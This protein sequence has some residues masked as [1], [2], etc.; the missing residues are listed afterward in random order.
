M[1]ICDWKGF[2][3]HLYSFAIAFLVMGRSASAAVPYLCFGAQFPGRSA[4]SLLWDA[5]PRPQSLLCV[6]QVCLFISC[7]GPVCPGP[8][9]P[10]PICSFLV[11]GLYAQGLYAQSL[12]A[13]IL[14]RA[15]MPRAYMPGA[16]MLTYFLFFSASVPL[17]SILLSLLRAK[18]SIPSF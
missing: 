5:V 13:H 7:F 18:L 9:C 3:L 1:D 11:S 8:I 6:W 14:Y 17:M 10:E 15:Y 16:C 2:S 12:Y 4:T